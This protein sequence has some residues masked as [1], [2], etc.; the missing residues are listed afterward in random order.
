[1]KNIIIR[2]CPSMG[3]DGFASLRHIENSRPQNFLPIKKYSEHEEDNYYFKECPAWNEWANSTY[4]Y[5][6]Q[7]DIEFRFDSKYNS[8][9]SDTISDSFAMNRLS[10]G[11]NWL[12]APN[13]IIQYLSMLFFWCDEQNVWIEQSGLPS[14][15]DNC[16]IIPGM[17]PISCWYRPLVVALKLQK[18][19]D[20]KIERGMPLYAIRFRTENPCN[21]ILKESLPTEEQLKMYHYDLT[22]KKKH[23]NESWQ[24]IKKRMKCPMEFLWKN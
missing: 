4:V 2:Y 13:P 1:M 20:I 10:P 23:P 3:I 11:I 7:E 6:A 21:I 24:L 22:Y 9:T 5:Y 18:D 14:G 17:F 15:I 16:E 8:M 12:Q 19:V